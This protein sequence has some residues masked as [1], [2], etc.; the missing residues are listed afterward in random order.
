MKRI[1]VRQGPK[2]YSPVRI[3]I[4]DEGDSMQAERVTAALLGRRRF[5]LA[6]KHYTNLTLVSTV[7]PINGYYGVLR[8]AR[9]FLRQGR[10]VVPRLWSNG[11]GLYGMEI[12][13]VMRAIRKAGAQHGINPKQVIHIQ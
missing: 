9:L 4:G 2:G 11:R 10:K 13:R 3:Y 1:L 8:N 5:R 7:S 6:L 12:A